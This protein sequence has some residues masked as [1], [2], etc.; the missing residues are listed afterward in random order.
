METM[1]KKLLALVLSFCMAL[2]FVT[3][4]AMAGT[5]S[6]GDWVSDAEILTALE[7]QLI[8]FCTAYGVRFN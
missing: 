4:A 8:P 2:S 3:S 7:E 5:T 1:K 6:S